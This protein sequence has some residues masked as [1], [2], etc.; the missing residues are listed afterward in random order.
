MEYKQLQHTRKELKEEI[1]QMEKTLDKILNTIDP[2]S[3][4]QKR[5]KLANGG[6]DRLIRTIYGVYGS[7]LKLVTDNEESIAN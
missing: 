6:Y 1:E 5:K 3:N 4:E 7:H 2:P